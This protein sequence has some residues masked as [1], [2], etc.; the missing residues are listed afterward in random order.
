M[1]KDSQWKYWVYPIICGST[2]L[3]EQPVRVFFIQRRGSVSFLYGSGFRGKNYMDPMDPDPLS[4]IILCEHS[5][6]CILLWI[7]SLCMVKWIFF[8][9]IV[10]YPAKPVCPRL[11][12]LQAYTYINHFYIMKN[13]IFED[14]PLKNGKEKGG[15]DILLVCYLKDFLYH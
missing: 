15:G 12:L 11:C 9:K 6:S 8:I 14:Y 10:H 13:I 3:L 4:L 2:D 1:L 5:G 7:G